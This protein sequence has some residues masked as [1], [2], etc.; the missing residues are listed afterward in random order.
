MK[1]K[2][3]FIFLIKLLLLSGMVYVQ[4]TYPDLNEKMHLPIHLPQAILFFFIT[5]LVFDFVRI[6][7]TAFYFRKHQL[8]RYTRDNFTIGTRQ[9]AL[10]IDI[11]AFIFSG[12]V[13]FN[14]EIVQALTAI[15]IFAAAIAILSKDYISNM[16]NGLIMMFANQ[17]SINDYVQIGEN[18]GNV[19]DMNLINLHILND[20]DDLIFIPNSI[21]LTTTVVNYTKRAIDRVSI[22][23]EN[24]LHSSE[25]YRTRKLPPQAASTTNRRSWRTVFSL[26]TREIRKDSAFSQVSVC[27]QQRQRQRPGFERDSTAGQPED[28]GVSGQRQ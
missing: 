10:I 13:L 20:D 27:P 6:I 25:K 23:F 5:H 1:I 28:C 15:S 26:R 2:S 24:R 8:P 19:M 9:L 14:I 12:L 18:K 21:V 4:T 16:I 17:I 3:L 22:E 11:V 7:L